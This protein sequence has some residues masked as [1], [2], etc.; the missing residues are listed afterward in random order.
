MKTAEQ[1]QRGRSDDFIVKLRK[2]S[3]FFLRLN[4]WIPFGRLLFENLFRKK[5]I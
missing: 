1:Q 5:V 3:I 2:T 4:K